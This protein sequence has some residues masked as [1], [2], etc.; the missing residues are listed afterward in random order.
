MHCE[1]PECPLPYA[2]DEILNDSE[3]EHVVVLYPGSF[4][5][6]HP[7]RERIDKELLTCGIGEHVAEFGEQYAQGGVFGDPIKLGM[8]YRVYFAGEG[9]DATVEWEPIT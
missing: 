9:E 5:M 6:M 7:L 8:P 2:L 4:S 3:T 1:S